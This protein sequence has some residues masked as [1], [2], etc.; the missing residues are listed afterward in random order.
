[1]VCGRIYLLVKIADEVSY[2]RSS[3]LH[4]TWKAGIPICLPATFEWYVNPYLVFPPPEDHNVQFVCHIVDRIFHAIQDIAYNK[5][6]IAAEEATIRKCED[7]LMLLRSI[8]PDMSGSFSAGKGA[9]AARADYLLTKM[10]KSQTDLVSAR[11]FSL[12]A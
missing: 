12:L 4:S 7:E 3:N 9:T 8:G 2:L 10:K 11:P 5:S 1:M 6:A